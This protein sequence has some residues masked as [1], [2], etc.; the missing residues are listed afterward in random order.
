M[1]QMGEDIQNTSSLDRMDNRRVWDRETL[2]K[3]QE[4]MDHANRLKIEE[5]EWSHVKMVGLSG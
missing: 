3:N 4:E 1:V 2:K 5:F